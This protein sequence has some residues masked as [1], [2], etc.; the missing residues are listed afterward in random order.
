METS[1]FLIL[2]YL[3]YLSNWNKSA[4]LMSLLDMKED[5]FGSIQ[6]DYLVSVSQIEHE[7]TQRITSNHVFSL[8]EVLD[9][10]KIERRDKTIDEILKN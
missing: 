8:D 1:H 7:D 3:K 9:L 2:K 5:I 10:I 6:L 4:S